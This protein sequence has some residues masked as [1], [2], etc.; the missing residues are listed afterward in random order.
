M[1]DIFLLLTLSEEGQV[2]TGL[3]DQ[4]SLLQR[5]LDVCSHQVHSASVQNRM[6]EKVWIFVTCFQ[7]LKHTYN[8]FFGQ[9]LVNEKTLSFL[10]HQLSEFCSYLLC[11]FSYFGLIFTRCLD[12]RVL[13][14][15]AILS[16][17]SAT[18]GLIILPQEG[19]IVV[20]HFTYGNLEPF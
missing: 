11:F 3:R 1:F 19:A 7:F 6:K 14:S 16:M 10:L 4:P 17:Q 20:T 18:V 13:I 15:Q 2:Q 8:A 12:F 5:H 9:M